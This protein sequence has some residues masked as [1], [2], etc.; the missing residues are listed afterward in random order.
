MKRWKHFVTCL[1]WLIKIFKNCFWK[2]NERR[3]HFC[4][5]DFQRYSILHTMLIFFLCCLFDQNLSNLNCSLRILHIFFVPFHILAFFPVCRIFTEKKINNYQV[6]FGFNQFQIFNKKIAMGSV[7]D[8][9]H[10]PKLWWFYPP[11][12]FIK[13]IWSIFQII[14]QTCNNL[15]SKKC[16]LR[17]FS[18]FHIVS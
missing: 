16:C 12:I 7:A 4:G 15:F 3:K 10:Q 18:I 2:E 14:I 5:N 17:I 6:C 11:K 9:D 8:S 13:N 1:L